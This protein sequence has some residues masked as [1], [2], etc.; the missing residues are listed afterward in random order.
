MMHC[1]DLRD[2]DYVGTWVRLNWPFARLIIIR[3][4]AR[5]GMRVGFFDVEYEV[6]ERMLN[7]EKCKSYNRDPFCVEHADFDVNRGRL[8]LRV[9]YHGAKTGVDYVFFAPREAH[10]LASCGWNERFVNL[11]H[12]VE[13][14]R[15]CPIVGIWRYEELDCT[16]LVVNV[17]KTPKGHLQLKVINSGEKR[18]RVQIEPIRISNEEVEFRTKRNCMQY[19]LSSKDGMFAVCRCT[20][21][22]EVWMRCPVLNDNVGQAKK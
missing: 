5:L 10:M 1:R 3:Q 14:D 2:R 19:Q 16:S 9:R 20:N 8:S 13:K 4:S 17:Y 12:K 11:S 18:G 22:K 15:G 21:S 6:A 7:G